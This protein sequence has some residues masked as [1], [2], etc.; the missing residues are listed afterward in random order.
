MTG[1]VHTIMDR[2]KRIYLI[3]Q[4]ALL[5]AFLGV[6]I[7][8]SLKFAPEITR[9]ISH[10]KEFREYLTAYGPVSALI[11]ILVV[12]LHIIIVVIPG[13]IVQM[14]GG[15]AFGTALGTLYAVTGTVIGT[16]I[17]FAATRLLGFSLV[18]ALISPKKLE[19]FEF[20]INNPKSEIGI[21][22]LFLIPGIPKD[23][24]VYLSGL[25]PI[26]PL[27]FL[28]ICTIARFPGILGSAYI[29]AN[30]QE[31]DYL[32]VWI[33]SGIALILFVVGILTKDKIIDWLQRLRHS[34]KGAP[35]AP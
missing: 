21:F 25:T 6:V 35:P 33:M 14:A 29:G 9:L 4:A 26:K 30:I 16:L 7:Y 23:T 13:E 32:P 28:A 31:K 20:L 11:Y 24:L 34:K 27:R 22:V 12:A 8:A 10:P 1:P 2:H 18:K 15:Y 17:V 19:K 3:T 5:A